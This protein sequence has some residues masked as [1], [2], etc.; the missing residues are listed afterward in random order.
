MDHSSQAIKDRRINNITTPSVLGLDEF[1]MLTK[2]L[3]C[4]LSQVTGSVR[5]GDWCTESTVA[6]GAL[7]AI[8]IRDFHQF[9]PVGQPDVA[10]Y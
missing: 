4:C 3:L 8:F 2:D 5:T 10:L 1:G 6:L 7:N 9:P